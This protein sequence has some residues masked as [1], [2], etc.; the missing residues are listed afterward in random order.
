VFKRGGKNAHPGK[1]RMVGRAVARRRRT[2]A[3]PRRG[4]ARRDLQLRDHLGEAR[5]RQ[6]SRDHRR[7][8][9]LSRGKN[10]DR[11]HSDGSERSEGGPCLGADAGTCLHWRRHRLASHGHLSG[12]DAGGAREHPRRGV[13]LRATGT[14]RVRPDQRRYRPRIIAIEASSSP[15]PILCSR[16]RCPRSRRRTRPSSG[17]RPPAG[18]APACRE[19]RGEILQASYSRRD[20]RGEIGEAR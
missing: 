6:V 19:R 5:A 11:R 20:R 9:R 13:G 12:S 14:L 10:D 1:P 8:N 18:R 15:A 7:D 4:R 17:G 16:H 3:R 2:D